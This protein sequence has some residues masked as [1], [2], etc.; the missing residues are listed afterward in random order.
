VTEGGGA[1]GRDAM[2]GATGRPASRR[3]ARGR[4][5]RLLLLVALVV[6]GLKIVGWQL[7]GSVS[8]LSDAAESFVNVAS[9]LAL[10]WAVRI[11]ARPADYE[12]PYGHQKAEYLSSVF[13]GAM[14]LVAAGA[15]LVTAVQRFLAPEPLE[16]VGLGLAVVVLATLVNAALASFLLR[17]GR[18]LRSAALVANGRHV[19]TDVWTSLGI[20]VGVAMVALTGVHRLDPIIAGVVALNIVREG[21]MVLTTNLSR[22]MDERLPADEEQVILDAL[23]RHP[24][25]RGYHRLRTRRSGRARFAEVDVFVDSQLSVQEAH[26]LVGE[27]EDDIHGQLDELIATLHVEPYIEGVRDERR[28]PRD[29]FP[30]RSGTET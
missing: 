10:I 28:A 12:H 11:A 14:I 20:V 9:A 17:E 13:E 4:A 19:R 30:P 21:V 23:E 6:V 15:I 24:G 1:R 26:A 5:A 29:E 8:L 16:R 7:T 25:V 3:A 22:L 18:A 2:R 27:V